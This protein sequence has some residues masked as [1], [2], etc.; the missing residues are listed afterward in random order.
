MA[1]RVDGDR[2]DCAQPAK[3]KTNEKKKSS[4]RS[5]TDENKKKKVSAIRFESVY[6]TR[7]AV[8]SSD[9]GWRDR[10]KKER[11]FFLLSL[12]SACCLV[13]KDWGKGEEQRHQCHVHTPCVN[14]QS[15]SVYLCVFICAR[16][17]FKSD[18]IHTH[19][20]S[21]R[22]LSVFDCSSGCYLHSAPK[23][24]TK[25]KQIFIIKATKYLLI[26]LLSRLERKMN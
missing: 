4:S 2:L 7:T 13:V 14:G 19:S 5:R 25:Q 8:L 26:S 16:S 9:G 17:L 1:V 3:R 18:Y 6:S 23:E 21:T 10:K 22:F 24:Q 12:T 11:L 20:V 15:R